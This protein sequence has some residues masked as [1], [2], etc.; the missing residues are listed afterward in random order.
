MRTTA[1]RPTVRVVRIRE[2]KEMSRKV[3]IPI[4]LYEDLE[5]EAKKKGF[6]WNTPIISS[7]EKEAH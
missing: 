3:Q 6:D 7:L 2:V 5:R 1:R 4:E